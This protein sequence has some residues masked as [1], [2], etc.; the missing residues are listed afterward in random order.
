MARNCGGNSSLLPELYAKFSYF[1]PGKGVGTPSHKTEHQ[2]KRG[3]SVPV[4]RHEPLLLAF[5]SKPRSSCMC[6]SVQPHNCQCQLLRSGWNVLYDVKFYSDVRN[7]VLILR[8]YRNIGACIRNQPL[9]QGYIVQ[10]YALHM[11]YMIPDTIYDTHIT[12]PGVNPKHRTKNKP[13]ASPDVVPI[14]M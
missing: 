6:G 5:S 7:S 11:A 9:G 3:S 2:C 13:W 10:G 8:F 14:K 1:Q 12:P 4:V